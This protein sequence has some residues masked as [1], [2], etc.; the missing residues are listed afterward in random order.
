M[1]LYPIWDEKI[2]VTLS[3]VME[4][5]GEETVFNPNAKSQIFALEKK[6][7]SYRISISDYFLFTAENNVP[8][9]YVLAGFRGGFLGDN[10]IPLDDI[11]LYSYAY[12]P[13]YYSGLQDPYTVYAVYKKQVNVS[14]ELNAVYTKSYFAKETIFEGDSVAEKTVTTRS[15]AYTFVGWVLKNEA[16]E[17]SE[18]DVITRISGYAVPNDTIF[19]AVFKDAEGNLV[20]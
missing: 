13:D 3:L 20:W 19:V 5:G 15:D 16:Q 2:N 9:G 11:P 10:L 12:A 17:Y 6:S 1:T 8:S 7:S 4:S 14:F 18:E